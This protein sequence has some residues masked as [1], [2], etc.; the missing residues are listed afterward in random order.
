MPNFGGEIKAVSAKGGVP[1]AFVHQ[2]V[3]LM[4]DKTVNFED[5]TP[6]FYRL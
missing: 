4:V 1:C 3:N 2:Q 5:A 6:R